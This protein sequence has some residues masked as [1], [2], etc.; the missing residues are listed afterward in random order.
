MKKIIAA[1]CILA[2]VLSFASCG[3]A[4]KEGGS[5]DPADNSLAAETGEDIPDTKDTDGD[6]PGLQATDGND[7]EKDAGDTENPEIPQVYKDFIKQLYPDTSD[8][9]CFLAT[10]DMNLDGM[11]EIIIA[12]GASGEDHYTNYVSHLVILENKNGTIRQLGDDLCNGGYSVYQVKLVRMQDD[13][14]KYLYCGLTNGV[15]LT[16]FK[17]IGLADDGTPFELC[18]SA[19]PTGAG[20]DTLMDFD[21]DGQY[22]GYTQ[23]RWSYDVLYYPLAR[24][25]VY[26]NN[27]FRLAE[28]VVMLPGYPEDIKG[29]ILQY[30]SLDAIDVRGS[31]EASERLAELCSDENAGEIDFVGND[32]YTPLLNTLLEIPDGIEFDID[33]QGDSA[34]ADIS[35]RDDSG[36]QQGYRFELVKTGGRWTITRITKTAG[37]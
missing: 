8:D 29:V 5:D 3:I 2:L 28:T 19:S 34:R 12:T 33:E 25:Y 20:E 4:R 23:N 18:C 15:S 37:Q 10:A 17:I 35:Y 14:K 27:A 7:S 13:P 21:N 32:I 26:E 24:K 36:T 16:G 6:V 11:N 1:V 30:L 22:D 9:V 31:K